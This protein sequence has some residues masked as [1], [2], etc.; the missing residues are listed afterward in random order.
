MLLKCVQEQF[1]NYGDNKR[2]VG[3]TGKVKGLQIFPL[4]FVYSEILQNF[5]A[6]SEYM[7]FDI[8]QATWNESRETGHVK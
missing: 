3:G 5:V 1:F 2:L 6:F 8:W 7:N 4:K